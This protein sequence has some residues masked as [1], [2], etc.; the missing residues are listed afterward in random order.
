MDR[1]T[2]FLTELIAEVGRRRRRQWR[3]FAAVVLG[4]ALCAGLI[5]WLLLELGTMARLLHLASAM[6]A[7][8][9]VVMVLVFLLIGSPLFFCIL[10]LFAP[11]L[12]TLSKTARCSKCGG[13]NQPEGLLNR[14]CCEV[15][16]DYLFS[17]SA[18]GE[19]DASPQF[20][21]ALAGMSWIVAMLTFAANN[22]HRGFDFYR[23]GVVLLIE[24]AVLLLI[25]AAGF[26]F[27]NPPLLL[28]LREKR[29]AKMA[30][31]IAELPVSCPEVA[32][33]FRLSTRLGICFQLLLLLPLF[34]GLW[35]TPKWGGILL[36]VWFG[37]SIIGVGW[38]ILIWER[39][40]FPA[41]LRVSCPVCGRPGKQISINRQFW[42]YVFRNGRC[43]HCFVRCRFRPSTP[44]ELFAG[45]S[46][47]LR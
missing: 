33:Y 35:L 1:E 20:W 9:V 26:Y 39:K 22:K 27:R 11:E 42:R 14:A 24:A 18:A 13:L 43:P 47:D 41:S 21:S 15:C 46:D 5:G 31:K 40:T 10:A 38:M 44:D 8:W 7:R 2:E 19:R 45:K 6:P 3:V 34:S 29:E 4:E 12:S 32:R 23:G 28:R 37:V 16:G 17:H 25:L 30:D 36:L